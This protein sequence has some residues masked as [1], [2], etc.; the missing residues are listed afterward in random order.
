MFKPGPWSAPGEVIFSSDPSDPGTP[1]QLQAVARRLFELKGTSGHPP[2]TGVIANHL[3]NELTRLFGCPVPPAL[4]SGGP[5]L[6]LSTTVFER[7]HLPQGCLRRSWMPLVV[8]P[9]PVHY[10]TVL[11]KW[12]WPESLLQNW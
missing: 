5:A 10:V 3:T 4:S 12:Y 1:E 11:P 7:N 2:A 8:H 6:E 9:G